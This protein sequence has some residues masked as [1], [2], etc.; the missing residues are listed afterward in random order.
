[1]KIIDE[2]SPVNSVG[3]GNIAGIGVGGA[4]EPGL[5]PSAM[6]RYKKGNQKGAAP[7]IGMSRRRSFKEFLNGNT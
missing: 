2:A 3:S 4:G 1:M 7:V 5:T 6:A